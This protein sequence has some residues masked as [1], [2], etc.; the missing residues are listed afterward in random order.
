[1]IYLKNLKN[2]QIGIFVHELLED[3]FKGLSGKNRP[4]IL[5]SEVIF[6]KY[7]IIGLLTH[8]EKG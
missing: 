3:T 1:M 6:R 4:S 7:W 2:R 8:L 5:S